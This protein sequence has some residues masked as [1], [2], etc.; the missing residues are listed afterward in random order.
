MSETGTL[1][2]SISKTM[3]RAA[4]SFRAYPSAM[5]SALAFS[6]VTMIRIQMDWPQ[7]EAYNLLFNSLQYSLALGAIFSLTAVAAAKSKINSTKSFIT[8]NS[9]GIAVGAVTFLLLYFFGGMKPTQDTARI[10][11]LTTLA[12]TRVMVAMLVSLLGFIVIVGYRG[13]KSDFSRSF[14]MTHKAFFTALLYG[15]V[16]LAGGSAIAGAV[17]ALLYKGMSGKVYMHISTIAGFLAYGIFIGYFPDFS[18]GASKRR[19]EKAQDQPGF[20]KT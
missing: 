6:I 3:K 18:K 8:A 7:Q 16:I 14:F 15:V 10:V 13:G 11:R 4:N 19:L 20:I 5:F 1:I 12:E 9:L 17:Q 2:K